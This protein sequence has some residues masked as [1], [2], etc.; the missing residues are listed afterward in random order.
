VARTKNGSFM[1]WSV[2]RWSLAS[3]HGLQE[4]RCV[5]RRAVDLIGQTMLAKM[6]PWKNF[7]HALAGKRI[8]L[9]DL[10]PVMSVGI[11]SGVNWM[12]LK[13]SPGPGQ[14]AYHEGSWP[15]PVHR[16]GAWRGK[17]WPSAV[18]PGVS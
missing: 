3:L 14:G 1:R 5:W 16:R 12:R 10:V 9:N 7:E 18:G 8:V 11:K 17:R 6:G 13:V 4:G 2:R 15:V